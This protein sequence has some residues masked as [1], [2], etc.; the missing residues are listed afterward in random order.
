MK[1][2]CGP[3]WEERVAAMGKWHP[4]FA[5]HPVRIGSH[6]CRWLETIE[7]RGDLGYG[8]W[9]FQYRPAPT[10]P[11]EPTHSDSGDEHA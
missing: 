7:R 11:A 9:S 6:D 1:L 5:W 2:N 10:Q 4:W 8:G 3:T